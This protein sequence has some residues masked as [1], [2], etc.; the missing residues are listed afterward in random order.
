MDFGAPHTHSLNELEAFDAMR[1]F[2]ESYWQRGMKASDDIAG[3][4]VDLNRDMM[5]DGGPPDP[6]QWNDWLLAIK[7][8]KN[9]T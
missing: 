4:L 2:L 9:S 1:A 5:G 8:I 6:A 3:L 7:K